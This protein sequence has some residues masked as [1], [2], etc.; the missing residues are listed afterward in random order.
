LSAKHG[1][2]LF[3]LGAGPGVADDA[4][5]ELA[6]RYPGV[7]VVGT[8]SGSPDD[9]HFEEIR[10][11][12]EQAQPQILLVAYGAPRQDMWIAQHGG[13]LPSSVRVAMGVG[14]VFDYLS[15]RVPLAP[16]I[17]RRAGLEWLYRVYKQPWRWKRIL[18]VFQFGIIVVLTA[19]VRV[20]RRNAPA[21]GE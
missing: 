11:R 9:A 17:M 16:G 1:Y 14:G 12:L 20:F 8:Y 4:A 13:G 5:K 18:K 21:N 10:T 6:L 3:L 2:R 19:S 15:G 7:R